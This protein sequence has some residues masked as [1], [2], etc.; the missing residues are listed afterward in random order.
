METQGWRAIIYD[1]PWAFFKSGQTGVYVS[2]DGKA[3]ETMN[4]D[5]SNIIVFADPNMGFTG[6]ENGHILFRQ[7]GSDLFDIVCLSQDEGGTYS[8]EVD[9]LEID[10]CVG[11]PYESFI[12]SLT[13]HEIIN[14]EKRLVTKY[15]DK[16]QMVTSPTANDDISKNK[17]KN[18]T[19]SDIPVTI[20]V[21]RGNATATATLTIMSSDS[22]SEQY[23]GT[24]IEGVD[25]ITITKNKDEVYTISKESGNLNGDCEG[26]ELVIKLTEEPAQYLIDLSPVQITNNYN[27]TKCG[28]IISTTSY[29]DTMSFEVE[30]KTGVEV[31]DNTSNTV[32]ISVK[33]G[34]STVKIII[35]TTKGIKKEKTLTIPS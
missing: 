35:T 31:V 14:G 6:R 17:F 33:S 28:E 20:T 30:N 13:I 1:A 34:I 5:K 27:V 15:E 21:S 18:D 23:T 2:E 24:D 8:L 11:E 16:K 12:R 29:T 19:D 9:N 22:Q 7:K 10:G 32:T 26:G 3:C 4:D 25:N